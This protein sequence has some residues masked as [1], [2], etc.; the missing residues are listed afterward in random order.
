MRSPG[1]AI[2]ILGGTFDPVHNGHKAIAQSFLGSHCIDELWIILSPH[3]PHKDLQTVASFS[4]RLKMLQAAFVGIPSINISDLELRLPRPSYTFRTIDYLKKTYPQNTFWLCLGEDS[5]NTF[6]SWYRWQKIV[7]HVQ[8]LVAS[9]PHANTEKIPDK[10]RS[11]AQ[12]IAHEPVS[13]SSTMIRE[14]VR[15]GEDIRSLVPAGV[16]KIINENMLYK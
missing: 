3:P 10:L 8:L 7:E 14:K 1:K 2:G 15:R 11:Q 13:V 12:F 9:R 16:A 5:F 4:Q 6:T